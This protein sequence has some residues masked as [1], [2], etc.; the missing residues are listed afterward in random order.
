MTKKSL[1]SARVPQVQVGS[2][3]RDISGIGIQVVAGS[4]LRGA[5]VAP[6]IVRDH[7][8]AA[9]EMVVAIPSK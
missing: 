6:A 8:R 9:R 4:R 1:R 5:T 3:F 2:Q 7:A